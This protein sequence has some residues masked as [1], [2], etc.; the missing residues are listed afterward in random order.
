MNNETAAEAIRRI[1]SEYPAGTEIVFV[2]T[3][4]K[5][6]PVGHFLPAELPFVGAL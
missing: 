4:L 2:L 5:S 6:D 1:A 3:G